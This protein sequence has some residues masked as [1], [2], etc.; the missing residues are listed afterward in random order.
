[1]VGASHFLLSTAYGLV[2]STS[3]CCMLLFDS[4]L[5]CYPFFILCSR[6]KTMMLI[7]L[8]VSWLLMIFTKIKFCKC[9]S[10]W[11]HSTKFWYCV[12]IAVMYNISLW[13]VGYL[14]L[15]F[16]INFLGTA[17]STTTK[18]WRK[19]KHPSLSTSRLP[20][21]HGRV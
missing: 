8:V 9:L 10:F 3:Y 21:C 1:M 6:F 18:T 11:L 19:W 13:F 16:I 4:H 7:L 5:P 2:R 15:Y 17:T 12:W 14:F 20:R